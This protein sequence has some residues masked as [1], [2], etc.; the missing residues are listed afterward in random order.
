MLDEEWTQN[1]DNKEN[2]IKRKKRKGELIFI[3]LTSVKCLSLSSTL[4]LLYLYK[5]EI[6]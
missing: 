6:S 3:T 1:K 4:F 2:Q 5:F